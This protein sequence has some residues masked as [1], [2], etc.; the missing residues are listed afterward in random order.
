MH[1]LALQNLTISTCVPLNI[2]RTEHGLFYYMS[3][4][5]IL[6]HQDVFLHFILKVKKKHLKACL[7]I[8]SFDEY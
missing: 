7:V 8:Y 2:R 4:E 5:S 6:V 1:H 3:C